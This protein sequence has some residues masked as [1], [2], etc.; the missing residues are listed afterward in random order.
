MQKAVLFA[1]AAATC[2]AL[3]P[4]DPAQA[5]P[6]RPI[7]M[8]VPF[9]PGG[10]TDTIGRVIAERMRV[11]LGQ[12]IVI[13]NISGAG[14][15]IGVGRAARAAPDGHTLSIGLISSHVFNGAV[16]S[17]PYD[18]VR[19]FDPVGVIATNPQ[20]I[21]TR[22]GVPAGNLTVLL[23]W[24]KADDR[25]VSAGMAGAGTPSHVSA[26]L[27]ANITG[28]RFQLIPYRGGAPALQGLLAG[29]V[30]LMFDQVANSLPYVRAGKLNAY[31]VTAPDRVSVASHIPTVDEA[32][33]PG[34]YISVWHGLWVPAG[35][36]KETVQKLNDALRDALTDPSVRQKL[37]ELG[38]DVPPPEQQTP[39]A[40]ALLQRAEIE[41]W[42]PIIRAANI[43]PN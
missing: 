40:L 17:L 9:A 2:A 13:E 37:A 31:A 5:Y 21:I 33:L 4:S 7:T 16:Y 43:K 23:H 8:I 41:K 32:G 11:S 19:D 10:P 34:F 36:P 24:L 1:F 38:H 18:L 15:T 14:G 35:T 30:D 42:W 12:P 6:S 29:E 25:A 26:V 3:L 27:F 39:D 20:L 22:R 28:V